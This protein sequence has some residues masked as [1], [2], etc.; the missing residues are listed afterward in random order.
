MPGKPEERI[1]RLAASLIRF[2]TRIK[3][4]SSSVA[5]PQCLSFSVLASLG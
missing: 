5:K 1:S 4:K 2:G 3:S